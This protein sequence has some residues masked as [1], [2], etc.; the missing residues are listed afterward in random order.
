M[1]FVTVWPKPGLLVPKEEGGYYTAG[2]VVEYDRNVIRAIRRGD[3]LDADPGA[4]GLASSVAID[5]SDGSTIFDVTLNNDAV[6]SAP[7]GPATRI[8]I[9]ITQDSAASRK[10][11]FASAYKFQ[12]GISNLDSRPGAVLT[13]EFRKSGSNWIQTGTPM[14][15]AVPTDLG[16]TPST[17]AAITP[18]RTAVSVSS[19]LTALQAGATSNITVAQAI[20]NLATYSVGTV[21]HT[22]GRFTAHDGGAVKLTVVSGT[23][24]VN[25]VLTYASSGG[26]SLVRLQDGLPITAHSCGLRL[27]GLTD[28][29]A[30]LQNALDVLGTIPHAAFRFLP[31]GALGIVTCRISDTVYVRS[32][33][34]GLSISSG[35]GT[36]MGNSDCLVSWVGPSD[37]P[38][39]SVST[40]GAMFSGFDVVVTSGY[41]LNQ[42]FDL[43]NAVTVCTRNVFRDMTVH[44]IGT[45]VLVNGFT[46]NHYRLNPRVGAVDGLDYV[47]GVSN[48][49]VEDIIFERVNIANW[50]HSAFRQSD[51]QPFNWRW[52]HCKFE[53]TGLPNPARGV[54]HWCDG[55]SASGSSVGCFYYNVECAIYVGG[56]SFAIHNPSSE[57][58]KKWYHCPYSGYATTIHLDMGRNASDGYANTSVGPFGFLSS[59]TS[60]INAGNHAAITLVGLETRLGGGPS[61]GKI[62]LGYGASLDA[63]GC[64]FPSME[65]LEKAPDPLDGTT[66]GGV[67]VRA[68]KALAPA[69]SPTPYLEI[70][71]LKG[72]MSGAVTASVTGPVTRVLIP[73][74]RPETDVRYMVVPS[75]KVL[76]GTYSGQALRVENQTTKDFEVVLSSAPDSAVIVVQCDVSYPASSKQ[77]VALVGATSFSE[78]S[79]LRSTSG[80]GPQIGA[81]FALEVLL[82]CRLANSQFA[83]SNED[84]CAVCSRNY[85]YT[86]GGY[87][88]ELVWQGGPSHKW[89]F[90]VGNNVA[91]ALLSPDYTDAEQNKLLH[92]VI[93]GTGGVLT[94]FKQGVSVASL[95]TSWVNSAGDFAVG[96]NWP[97]YPTLVENKYLNIYAINALS[98]APSDVEIAARFTAVKAA[99]TLPATWSGHT[100]THRYLIDGRATVTNDIAG[101]ADPLT[102]RLVSDGSL[103]TLNG[104]TYRGQL[105]SFF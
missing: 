66:R 78:T 48:G 64:I 31:K 27:D 55:A 84:N 83:N 81:N 105:P 54:V 52:I 29:T 53:Q 90:R 98:T 99:E 43:T 94:M 17:G 87:A 23:R 3:L 7:T 25:G 22:N 42:A 79:V 86:V 6:I 24:T 63:S 82:S 2:E 103:T 41:T 4:A 89:Q 49:N 28:D 67:Y 58:V 72:S 10:V 68:C 18:T 92:F 57:L 96:H 15:W 34:G 91:T 12:G 50:T 5:S 44:P 51:A 65:F 32:T 26:L 47:S 11:Y 46:C 77:R 39:F 95:T 36:G 75:V 93:R 100:L 19:A 102:L 62:T 16:A 30:A 97:N 74:E 1:S 38:A 20:T 61:A 88:F 8:T 13:L 101:G 45:G 37:K 70:N 76:S 80:T 59:D 40:Y 60:Y 56:D 69:G 104:P 85:S 21:I 73:L 33:S 9:N 71:E 14:G 35:S